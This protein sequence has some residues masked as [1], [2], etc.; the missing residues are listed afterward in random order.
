MPDYNTMQESDL[1]YTAYGRNLARNGYGYNVHRPLYNAYTSNVEE[2]KQQLLTELNKYLDAFLNF[3]NQ[4]RPRQ[5]EFGTGNTNVPP[6]LLIQQNPIGQLIYLYNT[7]D[8]CVLHEQA[9]SIRF[10]K[11]S[12]QMF[13]FGSGQQPIIAKPDI[14]YPIPPNTYFITYVRATSLTAYTPPN[15]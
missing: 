11:S 12:F 8:M 15:E 14:D 3:E 7:G 6:T 4:N 5:I 10:L 13:R 2:G 9:T 1:L